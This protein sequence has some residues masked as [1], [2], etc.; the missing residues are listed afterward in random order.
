M[1]GYRNKHEVRIYIKYVSLILELQELRLKKKTLTEEDKVI[2]G[3]YTREVDPKY[4]WKLTIFP[5][6]VDSQP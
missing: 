6:S 5:L 4:R 3:K 2:Y 1:V